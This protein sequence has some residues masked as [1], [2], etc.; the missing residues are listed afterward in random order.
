MKQCPKCMKEVDDKTSR[1]PFCLVDIS[2]GGALTRLGGS[3]FA[4]AFCVIALAFLL[5][6]IR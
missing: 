2:L 3:L 1:C 4:L 6:F 5:I